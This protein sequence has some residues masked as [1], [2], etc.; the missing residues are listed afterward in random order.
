[1]KYTYAGVYKQLCKRVKIGVVFFYR[2]QTKGLLDTLDARGH[3]FF[4]IMACRL[5]GAELSSESMKAYWNQ[6]SCA[7]YSICKLDKTP[8]LS[9]ST[10]GAC[11]MRRF[12]DYHYGDVIMGAMASQITSLT[13]VYSTVYLGVDLKKH[14]SSASLAFVRGI[15]RRPVNSLHKG[16]VMRKMFPFDDVIMLINSSGAE[17]SI[18]PE[19]VSTP[20]LV[21]TWLLVLLGHQQPW[22]WICRLNRW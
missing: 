20:W 6:R 18:S 10:I 7:L 1:M 19:N 2:I 9:T 8:L 3:H 13:I 11:V 22:C 17:T 16:T 12:L 4:Q 14:Q 21:M 5:F 15:H